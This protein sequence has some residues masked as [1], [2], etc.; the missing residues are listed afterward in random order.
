MRAILCVSLVSLALGSA[1]HS[2]GAQEKKNRTAE[3]DAAA[4]AFLKAYHAKDVDAMLAAADVPFLVGTVRDPKTFQTAD[5]LRAELKSRLSAGGKFPAQV[6]RTLTWDRAIN[7][8][9]GADHDKKM[10]EL[11]KPAI[12]ITGQD[13]GY[14]ALADP[15]GG[16]KGKQQQL[17]VASTRL[18]VGIRDGKAKVVGILDDPGKR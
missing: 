11:M 15:V 17:A 2:A 5:D 13:G 7:G 4:K 18:L 8:V 9:L 12:D 3:M 16:A 14:A 6:A 10:R 1:L